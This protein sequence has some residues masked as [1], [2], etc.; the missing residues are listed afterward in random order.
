MAS[1]F[2][3]ALV[4]SL[5]KFLVNSPNTVQVCKNTID[6]ALMKVN[7]AFGHVKYRLPA[8]PYA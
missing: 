7:S 5:E 8:R 6:I 1:N 3:E 2:T 4:K